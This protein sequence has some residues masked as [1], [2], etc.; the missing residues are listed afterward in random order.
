MTDKSVYRRP[1]D[2]DENAY[3]AKAIA[4]IVEDIRVPCLILSLRIK[5]G[6]KSATVIGGR[7]ADVPSSGAVIALH[8]PNVGNPAQAHPVSMVLHC[9]RRE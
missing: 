3:G 5:E 7:D 9:H 6:G 4:V 1:I 8:I 2:R